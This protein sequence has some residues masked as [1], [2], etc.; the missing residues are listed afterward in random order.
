MQ[1]LTTREPTA[2]MVEVAVSAFDAMRRGEAG[3][4]SR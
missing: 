4:V 2:D 1:R 3:E